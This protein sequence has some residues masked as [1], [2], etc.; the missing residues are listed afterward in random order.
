M[1][2]KYLAVAE[3][4]NAQAHTSGPWRVVPQDLYK[5]YIGVRGTRLGLRFKI[6]NVLSPNYD[7]ALPCEAEETAANARLI[8]ASPTMYEFVKSCAAVGN[9]KAKEIMEAIHA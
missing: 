9:E 5:P 1:S 2:E 6:A 8:A 3:T 7:G 4:K